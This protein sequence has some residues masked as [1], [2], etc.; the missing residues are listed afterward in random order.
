MS[1]IFSRVYIKLAE[2]CGLFVII[3]PGPFICSEWDFGGLPR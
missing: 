3:R 2:E 1:F